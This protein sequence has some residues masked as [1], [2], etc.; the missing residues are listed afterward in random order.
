MV[1]IMSFRTNQTD[2]LLDSLC[3]E[4]RNRIVA[5]G[6]P[7]REC[8]R[9]FEEMYAGTTNR[10]RLSPA[11]LVELT[12]EAALAHPE[13]LSL[14]LKAIEFM[15]VKHG[16]ASV[17]EGLLRLPRTENRDELL[18]QVAGLLEAPPGADLIN[19][20]I[21]GLKNDLPLFPV[22]IWRHSTTRQNDPRWCRSWAGICQEVII[23]ATL[24]SVRL[25]REVVE[26]IIK[27]IEQVPSPGE[28][29]LVPLV[30]VLLGRDSAEIPGALS[31]RL[32]NTAAGRLARQRVNS[33]AG[34]K[35]DQARMPEPSTKMPAVPLNP[36]VEPTLSKTDFLTEPHMTLYQFWSSLGASLISSKDQN[37]KTLKLELSNQDLQSRLGA[38][39]LELVRHR[40][41]L[42]RL[43]KNLEREREQGVRL[44]RE[45]E[46]LILKA[47]EAGKESDR[48]GQELHIARAAYD[49]LDGQATKERSTWRDQMLT[50]VL[51]RLQQ[52]CEEMAEIL[53]MALRGEKEIGDVTRM[54]NRLDE[55]LARSLGR[56]RLNPV[57]L[58]K[59]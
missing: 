15:P 10:K 56:D 49:R 17:L 43:Q 40:E 1:A 7:L 5:G 29:G 8:F 28:E 37:Q 2:P 27:V 13:P 20:L 57:S 38:L 3:D 33:L 22:Q 42:A 31:E 23:R 6:E 36:L 21:D 11:V 59:P 51:V 41:E 25:V 35:D 46:S 47:D 45:R 58:S 12:A 32:L 55:A 30:M 9:R 54:W 50:D 48:L 26:Q 34:L 53:E 19:R 44:L 24:K 39:E 4:L 14:L 18:Y 16:P 52:P